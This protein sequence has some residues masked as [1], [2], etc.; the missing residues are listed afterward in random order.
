M[1]VCKRGESSIYM[2]LVLNGLKN[3]V[4]RHLLY[5]VDGR[6]ER[7][8]FDKITS[9][10]SKLCYGLDTDHVDPTAVAQKVISGLYEGVKTTE[11]DNLVSHALKSPRRPVSLLQRPPMLTIHFPMRLPKLQHT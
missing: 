3:Y 2:L 10:L 11:L 5:R 6:K 9:R 8:Q 4:D 7:V 1:F